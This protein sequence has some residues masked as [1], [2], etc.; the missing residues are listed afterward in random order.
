MSAPEITLSPYRDNDQSNEDADSLPLRYKYLGE[1]AHTSPKS[2]TS[3][4]RYDEFRNRHNDECGVARRSGTHTSDSQISD[5]SHVAADNGRQLVLY[6]PTEPL[7]YADTSPPIKQS[8]IR[9]LTFTPQ[10]R[11]GVSCRQ[12]A[13]IRNTRLLIYKNGQVTVESSPDDPN[14]Q[15]KIDAAENM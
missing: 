2:P 13:A 4:T 7:E 5:E 1:A 3:A 10:E 11:I 8:C 15:C 9:V 12:P 6:Q 14:Q